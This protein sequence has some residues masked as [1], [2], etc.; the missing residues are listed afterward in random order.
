MK[1][2]KALC[3]SLALLA[4]VVAASA[5][6]DKASAE[7]WYQVTLTNPSW[8]YFGTSSLADSDF[9]KAV[10]KGD[11]FIELDNVLFRGVGVGSKFIALQESDPIFKGTVFINPK[12]IADIKPMVGDP[13]KSS[14][15]GS[16]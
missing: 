16:K 15:T 5:G 10:S 3:V 12:N 6:D 9:A 14:D 7:H 11:Q 2:L 13:R 8:I 4:I 1:S